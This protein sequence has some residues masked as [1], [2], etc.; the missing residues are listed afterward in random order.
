MGVSLSFNMS[1]PFDMVLEDLYSLFLGQMP[2]VETQV[3]SRLKSLIQD[4]CAIGSQDH[5]IVVLQNPQECY[6]WSAN[7]VPN[8]PYQGG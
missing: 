8:R 4:P 2:V 7:I 3:H 5:S 1:K 6:K